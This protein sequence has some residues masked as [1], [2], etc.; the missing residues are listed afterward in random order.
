[1]QEVVQKH[2]PEERIEDKRL[3]RH[4]EHD[5]LSRAYPFGAKAVFGTLMT[6]HHRR[7]GGPFDQGD[8][9]SCT[10]NATAGAINSVPFH[11]KGAKLLKEKD[12]VAIYSLATTLDGFDGDYPPDDTGS[13]GL[14]AAKAAK[15]LGYLSSYKHAFSI[16]EALA[17][18]Q[19]TPVITGVAWYE[20]FDNPNIHGLVSISGQVRGGHEFEVIGFQAG[21]NEDESLVICENSWSKKWSLN[22]RF[23]FSVTTWRK[24]LDDD[25]DV[26]I[27]VP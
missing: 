6:V 2:I 16:E 25:G 4:V 12:A 26:T 7:Y 27:L 8:L 23:T 19:I 21:R 10:G 17:A 24:L 13:S 22:G 1:M 5:P 15:S 11:K 20:G 9:G 3:G 18:L 14:A